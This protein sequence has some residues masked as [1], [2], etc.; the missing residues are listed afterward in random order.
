MA[1]TLRNGSRHGVVLIAALLVGIIILLAGLGFLAKRK[2]QYQAA[3]DLNQ[4]NQA[5]SLAQ[6]GLEDFRVKLS[7]TQDFPP[8]RPD[9]TVYAYSED[10]AGGSYTIRV[11]RVLG[12]ESTIPRPT[13]L[14]VRSEG[15]A[16]LRAQPRARR[17]LEAE[18]NRPATGFATIRDLGS[19]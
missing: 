4:A 2:S 15:S 19:L 11:Q 14:L 16:G 13:A 7:K 10:F 9:Q 3:A 12:L 17:V 5:L 18:V 8:W 6:A 1:Q